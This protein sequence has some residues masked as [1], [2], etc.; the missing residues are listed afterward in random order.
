MACP[1]CGKLLAIRV[2]SE[3]HHCERKPRMPWKTEPERLLERRKA[4]AIRRFEKRAAI[5]RSSVVSGE[6]V[7]V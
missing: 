3:K 1:G 6:S 7:V 5:R 2:L 4:A